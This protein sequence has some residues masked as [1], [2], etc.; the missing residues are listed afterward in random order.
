MLSTGRDMNYV[1]NYIILKR[2]CESFDEKFEAYI[3]KH[4]LKMLKSNQSMSGAK[5][6][7]PLAQSMAFYLKQDDAMLMQN[8]EFEPPIA[9]TDKMFNYIIKRLG[10]AK[11]QTE[12]QT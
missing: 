9:F 7:F 6:K 4:H 1:S 2:I 12:Q 3:R 11:S 5:A 8:D 10:L